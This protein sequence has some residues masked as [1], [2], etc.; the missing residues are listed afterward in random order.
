MCKMFVK[1][2]KIHQ[3]IED[4]LYFWNLC[5]FREMVFVIP[6]MHSSSVIIAQSQIAHV[7]HGYSNTN[8]TLLLLQILYPMSC[9]LRR[10]FHLEFHYFKSFQEHAHGRGTWKYYSLK[11]NLG[12]WPY[13]PLCHPF[14]LKT[15]RHVISKNLNARGSACLS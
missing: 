9:Q 12:Y 7:L 4:M 11:L 14:L 8:C 10:Q 15:K 5:L 3:G 6:R 13:S 1:R 2:T